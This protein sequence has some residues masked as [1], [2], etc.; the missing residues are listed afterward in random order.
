MPTDTERSPVGELFAHV[1]ECRAR[2]EAERMPAKIDQGLAAR[3]DGQLELLAIGSQDVRGI[4]IQCEIPRRRELRQRIAARR[5]V[6]RRG[7]H[8]V[9]GYTIGWLGTASPPMAGTARDRMQG[10]S[11]TSSGTK[12]SSVIVARDRA[13][14]PRA[15]LPGGRPKNSR[16]PTRWPSS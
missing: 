6:S 12:A 4:A 11:C 2:R 7:I 14:S 5:N 10:P 9:R 8:G 16:W 15:V 1:I 13:A 3:A